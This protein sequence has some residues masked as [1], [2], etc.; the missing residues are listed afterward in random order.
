LRLVSGFFWHAEPVIEQLSYVVEVSQTG[1]F[2]VPWW[3]VGNTGSPVQVIAALREL[4]ARI[5]RELDP[6]PYGWSR[7]TYEIHD[8]DGVLI[9]HFCGPLRT[10]EMTRQLRDLAV[11][12][13]RVAPLNPGHPRMGFH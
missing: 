9:E 3:R 1:N 12:I 4:A 10:C 2:H 13:G 7:F 11:R 8:Y 6:Y 5:D